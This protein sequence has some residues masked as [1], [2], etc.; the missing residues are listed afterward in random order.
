LT[1]FPRTLAHRECP[2]PTIFPQQTEDTEV[3]ISENSNAR[4][5][6]AL[7]IKPPEIFPVFEEDNMKTLT[8]TIATALI[9]VAVMA[10]APLSQAEARP[11]DHDGGWR[12][13]HGGGHHYRGDRGHRGGHHGWHRGH[14]RG[15]YGAAFGLGALTALAA[16]PYYAPPRYTYPRT[17]HYAPAY[18]APPSRTVVIYR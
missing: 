6:P 9:A 2:N 7:T 12:G 18:Y 14:D 11:H 8:K 16:R 1:I 4:N 5:V 13:H 3:A 17:V 15:Y 10:A